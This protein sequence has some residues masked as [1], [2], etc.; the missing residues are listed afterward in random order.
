MNPSCNTHKS[1]FSLAFLTIA[2]VSISSANAL[3][4]KN[5]KQKI[6]SRSE[7]HQKLENLAELHVYYGSIEGHKTSSIFN[8]YRTQACMDDGIQGDVFRFQTLAKPTARSKE[9]LYYC[10]AKIVSPRAGVVLNRGTFCS[11]TP[12]SAK[13]APTSADGYPYNLAS[14]P[15][16]TDRSHHDN[17]KSPDFDHLENEFN[18]ALNR[19]LDQGFDPFYDSYRM[20][21]NGPDDGVDSPL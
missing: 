13:N 4:C 7:I 6:S 11:I 18:H 19:G 2:F 12:A 8:V 3:E 9:R 21:S 1:L 14:D 17:E 10:Y 15:Y 20:N 5:V 16:S